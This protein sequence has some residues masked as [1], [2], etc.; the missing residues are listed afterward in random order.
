MSSVKVGAVNA[1]STSPAIGVWT[2]VCPAAVMMHPFYEDGSRQNSGARHEETVK[3][4]APEVNARA[5][6]KP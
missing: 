1:S 4:V 3:I 5:P 6:W 2:A